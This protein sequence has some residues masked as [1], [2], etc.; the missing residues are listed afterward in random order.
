MKIWNTWIV[1]LLLG[2][3]SS[4]AFA[5]GFSALVSP[6]RFEDRVKAGE[7]YRNVVE[8]S[9]ISPTPTH[10]TTKTADWSFKADSSVN[11]SE[12]LGADSCRPWVALESREVNIPA[13]GKKRFRFEVQ[14]P[15]NAPD[16]ECRFAV[17]IEGDPEVAQKSGVPVPVSGRIGVIVYLTIGQGAPQLSV[18]GY[19]KTTVD[20]R[21]LPAILVKNT[22]N[23]HG[24]LEGFAAGTDQSGKKMTFLPSNFPILPNET[25]LITLNPD[26]DR[27]DAPPPVLSFPVKIDGQFDWNNQKLSVQHQFP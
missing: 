14:I 4:S 23:A 7:T 15:A 17:M 10:L 27:P 25:R 21:V 16:G 9:N 20:G 11:F 5:Q 8:I 22:G 6:P 2:L 19:D 18:V 13:N 3:M 26:S 24:R 12:D 1:A